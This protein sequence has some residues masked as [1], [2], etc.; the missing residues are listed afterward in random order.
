MDAEE[1][2]W[3][4]CGKGLRKQIT[5][6]FVGKQGE[7]YNKLFPVYEVYDRS[8][9]HVYHSPIA[10]L[11]KHCSSRNSKNK[12]DPANG[13]RDSGFVVREGSRNP[14]EESASGM[15]FVKSGS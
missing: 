10:S 12:L 13:I 7:V 3:G 9:H 11:E 2:R 4:Q 5:V 1:K 8:N 15:E 6:W 14:Y